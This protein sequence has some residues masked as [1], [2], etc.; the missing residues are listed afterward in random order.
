MAKLCKKINYLND[1]FGH[2]NFN[3]NENVKRIAFSYFDKKYNDA[4][5]EIRWEIKTSS[6]I[7]RRHNCCG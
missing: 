1:Q 2:L 7:M 5:S 6:L 3:Q 4:V